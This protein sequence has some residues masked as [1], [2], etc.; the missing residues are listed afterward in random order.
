MATRA[1]REYYRG[2]VAR[3]K[4]G[5]DISSLD[6]KLFHDEQRKSWAQLGVTYPSIATATDAQKALDIISRELSNS[7][8]ALVSG[9]LTPKE[10]NIKATSA[11]R[12][13]TALQAILFFYAKG[14]SR[15]R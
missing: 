7:V 5:E 4:G 12:I 3:L 2:I 15:K 10:A 11:G 13:S 9:R 8:K 14:A 1:H 6:W